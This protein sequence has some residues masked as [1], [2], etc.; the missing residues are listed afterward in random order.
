VCWDIIKQ[1]IVASFYCFYNLTAGPLPKLNGTLLTLLPKKEVLE[2]PEDY[3]PISLMH[4][5][6]KLISKVLAI[7][8]SKHIN[9]LISNAQSAFIR[10]RCIQDNFLYV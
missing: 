8:M 2:Q 1:K 9:G 5:F 6:T 7:G 10:G 3:M 4:S